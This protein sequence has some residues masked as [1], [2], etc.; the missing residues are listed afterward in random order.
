MGGWGVLLNQFCLF[1]VVCLPCVHDGRVNVRPEFMKHLSRFVERAHESGHGVDL[2]NLEMDFG[3]TSQVEVKGEKNVAVGYCQQTPTGPKIVIN[4]KFWKGSSETTREM[5]IFHECGHCLLGRAHREGFNSYG[6]L[7]SLMHWSLPSD[8]MYLTH[9]R[10]YM[11]ELFNTDV[12]KQSL[13][14]ICR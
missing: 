2:V 11:F 13:G 7:T 10:Y 14:S 8:K 12:Q 1:L 4:E 6:D 5:L 3:D 9:Y